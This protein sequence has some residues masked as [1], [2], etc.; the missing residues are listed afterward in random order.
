MQTI[1]FSSPIP[2]TTGATEDRQPPDA[3]LLPGITN[4]NASAHA[5]HSSSAALVVRRPEVSSSN[6]WQSPVA[7]PHRR[8]YTQTR[9]QD[10]H[11][12]NLG[13]EMV[14]EL[15]RTRNVLSAT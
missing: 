7:S 9:H 8:D 4:A 3:Y 12:G 2:V 1:L 13:M 10:K 15:A 6:V 14:R 11:I 5:D